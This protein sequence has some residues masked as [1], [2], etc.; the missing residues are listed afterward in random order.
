MNIPKL[1][2]ELTPDHISFLEAFS[3]SCRHSLLAMVSRAQSG[4]PGGSCSSL[5]YLA[6]LYAF[7]L[8]Q[9][10]EKVITSH[11][12]ISPAVYSVLAEMKYIPKEEVI[13]DFRRI[14]SIY[15]GH[16]TRHVPG[17]WF[18]TGPLGVG[19]SAATGF[20]AGEYFKDSG[21]TVYALMGDGE[22]QEGQVYEMMHF[23][24][25][26]KQNNFVVFVDYN[27]V[28]LTD[29]L[30]ET[31]PIDIKATFT[32]A[33]WNVI[34]VNG[35]DYAAMW[36]ALAE[37]KASDKPTVIIGETIM[38]KGIELLEKDGRD[39]KSTWHGK[40]PKPEETEEILKDLVLNEE[41]R[42][43]VNEF[44]GEIKW[45]PEK[46]EFTPLLAE[47]EIDTGEPIQYE[48]GTMGDCRGA[49]GKALTDLAKKNKN[50]VALVADLRGSVK[51]DGV[52]NEVPKQHI[53]VGIAEQH[54]VSCAGGLSLNGYIPFCS[55]FGAFMSS[56]A[57]DQARMNDIN[58]TNV[59]M[60][61][62][63]C[64]LSVGEDG[65]THQAIDDM[66]SFLGMFNTMIVE[67]AD[68]NQT[69]KIIRYVASHYGNFYVRMGRHKVPMVTKEDGSIFYDENYK[70]EYG[71]SDLIRE[72]SDVTI[73]ASGSMVTE[74][75]KAIE[76]VKDI[77][78]ELIAVS[79][80]KKFDQTV[81]D[82]VKKTGKV[83][84]VE[85]HNIYSG[86]GSQLARVLE[87]KGI[88]PVKFEMMGV[89]EYQLSGKVNEL[90]AKA[91]IASEDIVKLAGS[92]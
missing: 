65:P 73:I 23:A 67:P 81:L 9:T 77:S 13:K 12:H 68:P 24:N 46:P 88:S 59:K 25:K 91:G 50:V 78:V 44:L 2:S 5:D 6:M 80:C 14:G 38:G 89:R 90:Y 17:V 54:M 36:K 3:K 27:R 28:Q 18:G 37:A 61:A 53:E 21:E 42:N 39:L 26:Y 85:D 8:S 52:A 47:M 72:G 40:S 41:E 22:A 63:H 84:T 57:K 4:H 66:G 31:M 10:G 1:D 48:A 62:T 19:V 45:Q 56:R 29:S 82:S 75:L 76:G 70:F 87:E 79:S 33:K 74:A 30:E 7:V 86:L 16:V 11:G 71:K 35:H 43:L 49:Y 69:D 60:V 15:E 32:A 58:Q 51:T 92:L 64:G 34:E 20:A 83:I 55:T